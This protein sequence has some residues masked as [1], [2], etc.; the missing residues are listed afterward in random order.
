[1]LS[2]E[3]TM[4]LLEAFD[5]TR[6]YRAAAQLCGV[7]HHTVR[8][9]VAARAAGHEPDEAGRVTIAQPFTDKIEELVERSSGKIRADATTGKGVVPL[10]SS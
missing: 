4:E 2:K 8:R 6:S 1:M 7:D 3:K 9:A 5:L 10:A